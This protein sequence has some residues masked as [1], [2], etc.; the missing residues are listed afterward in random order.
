MHCPCHRSLPVLVQAAG[1]QSYSQPESC[2]TPLTPPTKRKKGTKISIHK[3]MFGG[4][5]NKQ[6][7]R[8]FRAIQKE[9][10]LQCWPLFC[11]RALAQQTPVGINPARLSGF[12][13][14]QH[15]VESLEVFVLAAP[16]VGGRTAHGLVRRVDGGREGKRLGGRGRGKSE[17]GAVGERKA[18]GGGEAEGKRGEGGRFATTKTGGWK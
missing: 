16:C 1:G 7:I 18:G 6:T 12:V 8:I 13:L 9:V 17:E 2:T 11:I 3:G 14:L 10:R 15:P 4:V 5:E